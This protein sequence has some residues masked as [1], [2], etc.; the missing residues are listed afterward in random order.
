MGPGSQW[1]MLSWLQSVGFWVSPNRR[2]CTDLADVESF[3]RRWERDRRLLP[4]ATDGVMVKLDDLR[5]QRKL[6]AGRKSPVWA[7]VV[8]DLSPAKQEG[9]S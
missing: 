4:Y 1:E 9:A 6:W 5:L 2:F 7:T 3:F 8:R